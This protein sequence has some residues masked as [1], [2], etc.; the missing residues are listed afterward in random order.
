MTIIQTVID[1]LVW[2]FDTVRKLL[3]A[4]LNPKFWTFG[5]KIHVD[6]RANFQVAATIVDAA[7]GNPLPRSEV[8]F[9]DTGLDADRA[10]NPVSTMRALGETDSSGQ[11]KTDFSYS[12][13]SL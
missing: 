1:L 9:L 10:R 13:G 8:F 3:R 4:L 12:W 11:F 6:Y 5:S 7:S 2:L